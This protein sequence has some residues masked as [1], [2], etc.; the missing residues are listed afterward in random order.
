MADGLGI[1]L[2]EMA[3]R[4]ICNRDGADC[5]ILGASKFAHLDQNI[6][7]SQAGPLPEDAFKACD[8]VWSVLRG[9]TPEYTS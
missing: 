6:D 1:S 9:P 7:A 3:L 2:A 5:V 4:W 8:E